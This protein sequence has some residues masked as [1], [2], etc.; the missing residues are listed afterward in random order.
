MKIDRIDHIILTVDSIDATIKFYT[1]ILGMKL[2][3][4]GENR[5]ALLF[6]N[7]KINLHEK[8]K[9][10]EP[11]AGTPTCGSVDLCFITSTNIEEVKSELEDK[12]IKI[13]KGIVNRTGASGVILSIYFRDPDKN[14]IEV[15]NYER[16]TII[17]NV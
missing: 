14:L 4:F 16:K 7:Q 17:G 10:F 12:G 9:E 3:I 15:S 8:G 2:I 5:K 11:K 6:G 13:I 1:E